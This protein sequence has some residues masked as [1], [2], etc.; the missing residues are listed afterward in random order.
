MEQVRAVTPEA[1]LYI[2]IHNIDGPGN[3]GCHVAHVVTV[4]LAAC[5]SI[6][7]C[8]LLS[9][10]PLDMPSMVQRVWAMEHHLSPCLSLV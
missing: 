9:Q 1:R 5:I 7:R 4:L 2:L 6:S 10:T 8:L 3:S